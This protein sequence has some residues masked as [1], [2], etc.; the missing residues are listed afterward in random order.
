MI[1]GVN[2]PALPSGRVCRRTALSRCLALSIVAACGPVVSR[3]A[4]AHD[5]LPTPRSL[6]DALASAQREGRPL[7]ALFSRRGCPFCEALRRE[8]LAHL[9][10]DA[11]ARGVLVVE[12]DI[13]DERAFAEAAAPAGRS[14]AE[15]AAPAGRSPAA[16]ARALRIRVAPTV[17]FLGPQGELAQRLVGYSSP[18][19]YAA[20]LDERIEQARAAIR[21]AG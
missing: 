4:A 16:L 13:A 11:A 12:F 6:A 20:Y 9:A 15:A 1:G 17:A 19:F 14:P 8:Q 3:A 2:P 18:D 21:R 10:R 7:V 5:S